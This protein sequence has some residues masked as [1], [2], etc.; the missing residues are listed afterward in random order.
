MTA[1]PSPVWQDALWAARL[2]ALA[3]WE[4][5]GVMLHAAPGPVRERW[6]AALQ[7]CLPNGAPPRRVPLRVSDDSLFGGL[8]FG[9]TLRQG[10]RSMTTGLLV[11]SNASVLV[12]SMAERLSVDAVARF[13]CILD[14]GILRIERDGVSQLERLRIGLVALDE[15]C[16]GEAGPTEALADRLACRIDLSEVSLADA[17]ET[18]IDRPA[19]ERARTRLS[20][21]TLSDSAIET[22]C[23]AAAALSISSMRAILLACRVARAAAALAERD[24]VSEHDVKLAARLVLSPRALSIPADSNEPIDQAPGDADVPAPGDAMSDEEGATRREPREDGVGQENS[25]EQEALNDTVIAAAAAAIPAHVLRGLHAGA[26]AARPGATGCAGAARSGARRG[27]PAGTRRGMPGRGI[28][29]NLIETMRAAAPWQTVRRAALEGTSRA[30][31]APAVIVRSEDLRVNRYVEH[32]RTTTI[33]VV[34]ASGSAALH[35]LAEAKGAVELLLAECYVRRDQVAVITFRGE[36]S[37]LILPPTRSLARARRCLAG[38]PGGG[39][40]PLAA[41]IDA[42]LGLAVEVRRRADSVLVVCLTDARANVARDGSRGRAVGERDARSAA[43][44]LAASGVAALLIDTS[45]EPSQAARA[46]AATMHAKY[47]ALPHA[48][49]SALTE[50]IQAARR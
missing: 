2:T 38:V 26:A 48:D 25:D 37:E 1:L 31:A 39:A 36:G 5:G 29:L 45:P 9:A 10:R 17:A 3:P 35:R 34:D 22:L 42:A 19:L 28:R 4:L 18:P 24:T 41:A 33:F 46:L 11:G 12:L 7:S 43:L 21:V 47:L 32:T 40:T 20:Q 6:L 15:S 16:E 8:D 23:A 50:S 49:A 27:R 14:T 13:T 44:S 30:G